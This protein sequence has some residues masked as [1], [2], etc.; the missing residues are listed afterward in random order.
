MRTDIDFARE[1]LLVFHNRSAMYSGYDF[2]FDQF[3]DQVGGGGAKT[4]AFLDGFGLAVRSI[5]LST[6]ELNS[7]MQALADQGQGR[8]PENKN[9]FFKALSDQAQDINWISATPKIIAGVT[10]DVVKGVAAGGESVI[11]TLKS[12]NTVLPLVIVGGVIWFI[13]QKFKKAA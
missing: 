7:A 1:A 11:T 3:L 13:V 2:T 4:T 12:L 9:V 6:S 8:I 5:G 10:T